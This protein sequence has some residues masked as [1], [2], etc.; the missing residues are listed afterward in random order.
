MYSK[1]QYIVMVI[2]IRIVKIFIKNNEHV[3]NVAACHVHFKRV[4]CA[5]SG[6]VSF[7]VLLRARYIL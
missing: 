3:M 1:G 6:V 5:V 4:I 7:Y 2:E